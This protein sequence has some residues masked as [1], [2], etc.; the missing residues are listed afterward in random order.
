MLSFFL[1]FLIQYNKIKS[2]PPSILV[3][4]AFI[5]SRGVKNVDLFEKVVEFS[6]LAVFSRSRERMIFFILMFFSFEIKVANGM[7]GFFASLFF[8]G[9]HKAV[10][11][12]RIFCICNENKV[13]LCKHQK[14]SPF[15]HYFASFL[16]ASRTMEEDT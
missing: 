14:N 4:L 3:E 16:D 10:K 9:C 15:W 7:P 1:F 6:F 12:N 13:V 2:E 11:A 8:I 5:L